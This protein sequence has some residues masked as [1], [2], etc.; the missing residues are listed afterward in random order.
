M[1]VGY[2]FVGIVLNIFYWDGEL[3]P[4]YALQRLNKKN[5]SDKRNFKH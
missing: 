1:S 2:S 3:Q 4:F 5:K